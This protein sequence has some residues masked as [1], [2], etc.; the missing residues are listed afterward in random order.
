MVTNIFSNNINKYSYQNKRVVQKIDRLGTNALKVKGLSTFKVW[1]KFGM[2][3][4][5]GLVPKQFDAA[6]LL[7]Q[8]KMSRTMLY[9]KTKSI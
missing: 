1:T 9:F 5:F 2:S 7:H 3:K 4:R 8:N 6:D